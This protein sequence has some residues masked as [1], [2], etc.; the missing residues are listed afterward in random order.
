LYGREGKRFVGRCSL[1]PLFKWGTKEGSGIHRQEKNKNVI[2]C[3]M[4]S[5]VQTYNKNMDMPGRVDPEGY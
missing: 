4:L 3:T 5:V 2:I 1:S